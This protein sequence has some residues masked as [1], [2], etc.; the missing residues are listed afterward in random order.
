MNLC[1]LRCHRNICRRRTTTD[2]CWR[3]VCGFWRCHLKPDD[4]R[5]GNHYFPF[6]TE[7]NSFRECPRPRR[8][9]KARV[10]TGLFQQKRSEDRSGQPK[11]EEVPCTLSGQ[12]PSVCRFRGCSIASQESS[13]IRKATV[14]APVATR[15]ANFIGASSV[16]SRHFSWRGDAPEHSLP[17]SERRL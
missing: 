8:P 5:Q 2:P 17:H 14:T 10:R 4:D 12:R 3:C 9:G 1:S 7:C 11:I 16:I 13:F 6:M 15:S